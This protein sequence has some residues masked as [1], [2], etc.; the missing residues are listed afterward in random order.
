M[1]ANMAALQGDAGLGRG[2]MITQHTDKASLLGWDALRDPAKWPV[3]G[4][5]PEQAGEGDRGAWDIPG[6]LQPLPIPQLR[7]GA[8][9]VIGPHILSAEDEDSPAEEVTYSIQPPAN[10]KVVLRSA[11][12][13]EVQQFTQAQINNGLILFVH[14]GKAGLRCPSPPSIIPSPREGTPLEGSTVPPRQMLTPSH[15][16]GPNRARL[17]GSCSPSCPP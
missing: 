6:E 11:P 8:T 1:P 7:E 9:A 5:G 2:Q 16:P 12:G 14:Q 3:L 4:R 17:M 15:T 10:G 13:T